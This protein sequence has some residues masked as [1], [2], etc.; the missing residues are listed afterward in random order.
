MPPKRKT[1]VKTKYTVNLKVDIPGDVV[2]AARLLP[3]KECNAAMSTYL[4][5]KHNIVAKKLSWGGMEAPKNS[6]AGSK[7]ISAAAKTEPM[8]YDEQEHEDGGESLYDDEF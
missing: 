3:T 7:M 6:K 4:K 8:M 5:E 2:D 1:T